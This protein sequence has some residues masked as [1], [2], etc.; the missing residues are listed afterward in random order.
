MI[1]SKIGMPSVGMEAAPES[2]LGIDGYGM[3]PDSHDTQSFAIFPKLA[4]LKEE[5]HS[6]FRPAALARAVD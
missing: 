3:R 6:A 5:I 1:S 2:G 4:I